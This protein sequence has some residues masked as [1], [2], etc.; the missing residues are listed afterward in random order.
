MPNSDSSNQRLC[1]IGE[2]DPFLARL[3]QRF[4][5]KYGIQVQLA[6]TGDEVMELVQRGRPVL[7]ILEPE[8]PG[9]LRGWEAAR[10]L[11]STAEVADVPL[12]ICTWLKKDEA[13]SLT[14]PVAAYLQ[15]PDL[16]FKDFA[17]AL[18]IAGIKTEPQ[19]SNRV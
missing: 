5:E 2:S 6:R 3:L 13:I 16:H 9:K 8:L 7:I 4:V 11:K 10:F 12:M 19:S 1:I 17:A 14:G 18:E 15:K